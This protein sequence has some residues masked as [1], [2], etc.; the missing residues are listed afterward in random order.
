MNKAS[1][2][3]LMLFVLI[4]SP[5]AQTLSKSIVF[6]ERVYSFGSIL[7]KDGEVSH[8]FVFMNNS[9]TPVT[10]ADVH[11]SC[12]CIG[13]VVANGPVKPGGKGKVTITF[14]PRY[15]SGFFSKEIIVFS[16]GGKEFNRIWVEGTIKPAEH[17][18]TDAYPYDF[19]NGLYL[20]LKVLAFGYMKPGETKHM[21]LHYAN[22]TNEEMVLSFLT[23]GMKAG[24]RFINPGK[25]APKQK[26][27]IRISYSMSWNMKEDALF[28]LIPYVNQKKQRE[29]VEVKI[30]N[31][32]KRTKTVV[33]KLGQ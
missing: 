29:V 30:L 4:G 18:V 12:G 5:K 25:I 16:N 11:S 23:E 6:E 33:P 8:S 20:R 22:D 2:I 15:K 32:Y 9:E 27:V 1:A 28:R 17:P 21:E 7:E 14:D 19:G 26:G 13:K 10:I 31:E 3:F 24:L